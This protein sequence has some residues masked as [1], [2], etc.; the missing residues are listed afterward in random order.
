MLLP[1]YSLCGTSRQFVAAGNSVVLG[2]RR[3]FSNPRSQNRLRE[4]AA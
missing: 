4:Y 3:T 2:A 1:I